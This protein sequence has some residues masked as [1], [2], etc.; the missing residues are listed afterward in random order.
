[1]AYTQYLKLAM[2]LCLFTFAIREIT[3][4]TLFLSPD[5]T[6]ETDPENKNLMDQL[7][8]NMGKPRNY[9]PTKEEVEETERLETEQRLKKEQEERETIERMESEEA[10]LK[11]QR[12]E[13]WVSWLLVQDGG[14]GRFEREWELPHRDQKRQWEFVSCVSRWRWIWM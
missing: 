11:E 7:V 8:K 12:Q 4:W 13:E 14:K 5:I 6:K 9:G 10:A 2:T 1:M 3:I